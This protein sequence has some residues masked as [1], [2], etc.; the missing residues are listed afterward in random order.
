[1]YELASRLSYFLWSSM[2][3]AALFEAAATGQLRQPAALS[4]QV[5][6]LLDSPKASA[7]IDSFA[8]QW[9]GMQT[10]ESHAVLSDSFPEWDEPLRGAVLGEAREYL[11]SFVL[12]DAPWEDFLSAD[13]HFVNARLAAHYAAS[14]VPTDTAG[15]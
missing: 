13:L 9:L 14:E 4:A 12:G 11:T 2:P 8:W 7:L 15:F 5:E 10:L 6:R 1:D 3:D